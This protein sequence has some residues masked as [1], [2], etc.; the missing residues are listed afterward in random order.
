M[1]R[2]AL[3][4]LAST[5]I[6][7][8]IGMMAYRAWTCKRTP[9][10][11]ASHYLNWI[12]RS[13][14]YT[15]FT[16]DLEPLN[17]EHLAALIAHV[18]ALPV[19]HIKSFMDELDRDAELREHIARRTGS[20]PQAALADPVARYGR[21]AGWYALVRA[22]RPSVVIETGVDKGLG[23]VVL[24]AALRRN[25]QEGHPGRYIGT[26]ISPDAGHLLESPY[27]E[28][29]EVV[30]GD[31]V[32]TLEQLDTRID[33]FINDSDHSA[34]YEATEYRVV[35]DKLAQDAFV[36]GDNAH[37]T[38]ELFRFAGETKRAFLFFAEKPKDHWYPGAG[39]GIAWRPELPA[40]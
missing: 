22:S 3:R 12:V 37:V 11:S 4:R 36:L 19:E 5:P 31:S 6:F 15:N 23:S 20:K 30:Y 35:A 24:C 7:G 26:D 38:N 40:R 16:Y 27:S 34:Q 21:R 13:R 18:T 1:V 33:V 8:R 25:L 32:S 28:V 10:T 2:N 17:L 14:E 29:G 39:I 9:L